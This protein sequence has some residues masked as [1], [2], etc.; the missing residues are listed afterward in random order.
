MTDLTSRP[1]DEPDL[2]DAL[3]TGTW[4]GL[5]PAHR[6]A[7]RLATRRAPGHVT[8]ALTSPSRGTAR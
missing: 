1:G 8:T 2:L 5:T 7:A 4:S 6:A 3:R